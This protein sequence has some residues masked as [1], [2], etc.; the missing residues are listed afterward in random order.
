MPIIA[1]T[2]VIAVTLSATAGPNLL[3]NG[4]FE[5]ATNF[6]DQGDGAMGAGPGWTVTSPGSIAWIGPA[7]PFG[8]FRPG[9]KLLVDHLGG[10][11]QLRQ[12]IATTPGEY[13]G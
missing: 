11:G 3:T 9:R 10:G 5:D 2:I 13:I 12:S 4:G 7:F 1:S 8:L 6:L